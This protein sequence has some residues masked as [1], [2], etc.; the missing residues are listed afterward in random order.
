MSLPM[1]NG[2]VYMTITNGTAD[3]DALIDAAVPGCDAV[4]LHEMI[5]ENDVMVMRQMEG[6]RIPI[7][8][9]ETVVLQRGGL[10]VMCIGKTAEF[11]VG[12]SVP[13]TLTFEKAGTMEVTAEVIDP[14]ETAPEMQMEKEE[15]GMD[16]EQ[17]D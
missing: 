13:V 11:A 14:G 8:A 3:D 10:H 7:P 2:A 5:M 4:E 17:N 15:G 9:G 6:N 16:M 1:P 12:E